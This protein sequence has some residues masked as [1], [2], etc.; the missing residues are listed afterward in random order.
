MTPAVGA[1][2]PSEEAEIEAYVRTAPAA[3]A[4]HLPVFVRLVR[5]AGVAART[6]VAREGP[7]DALA[8]ILPVA[9]TQSPFFGRYATS[10]PFFN[11]GGVL[12]RDEPTARALVD[13]AWAWARARGARHLVL[14]H[15]RDRPLAFLPAAHT[16]ET[17]TLPLPP[18]DPAALFAAIGSKTRNLV[19]KGQKAGL[20]ASVEGEAGL[21]AFH[22]VYAERM[23]DLGTPSLPAAFFR[24]LVREVGPAARVHVVRAGATPAAAAVTIRF[25]DRVE[26]PWAASR[27][28][29]NAAAANML[30]YWHLLED[31]AREGARLFDFGRSTPGSGPYRFKL[32]WGARPEPL[33][34][35]Y[36]AAEGDAPASELSP[37]NPRYA[38]AI[39]LWRR[40]PLGVARVLGGFLA[41]QLP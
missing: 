40:L 23:R 36:V 3:V 33:P 1:A 12:A 39:R 38:L 32:Q 16:K 9:C 29:F 35:Y 10:L 13:R 5:A 30:L 22:R 15:T 19:R 7:R 17:L 2:G 14:R 37:Q 27:E 8:G 18:G 6:F 20:R 34:W 31:S 26:V 28:R 11:T 4:Y 21:G 25:R 24:R 41:T